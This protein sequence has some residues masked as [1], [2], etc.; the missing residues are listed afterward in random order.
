MLLR[1]LATATSRSAIQTTVLVSLTFFPVS[2]VG[3]GSGGLDIPG[4]SARLRLAGIG[5]RWR[6]GLRSHL[7][8]AIATIQIPISAASEAQPTSND[9][10]RRLIL[11]A[12]DW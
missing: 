11:C 12:F 5:R 9:K 6:G 1:R 2:G 10:E 8:C 7:R 4:W 3:G